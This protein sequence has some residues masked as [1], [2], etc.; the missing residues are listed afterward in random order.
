MGNTFKVEIV[1]SLAEIKERLNQQKTSKGKERMQMLYWLKQEPS[2]QRQT[3]AKRLNRNES[4][5]YRWLQ[6]YQHGGIDGL[7]TV[8]I[9]PGPAHTI[10]GDVLET[11]QARLSEARGFASYGE[12]QQWLEQ[13]CGLAIPYSTVH[14]TVRYRLNAKLKAPRPRSTKTDLV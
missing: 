1:D 7:L 14:R 4:T 8:R 3:L 5:V 6:T 9:A 10:S 11:L 2:I 12:I 13:H